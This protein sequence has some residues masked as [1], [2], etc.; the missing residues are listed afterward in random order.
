MGVAFA[1]GTRGGRRVVAL[2]VGAS[3]AADVLW[4]TLTFAGIEGGRSLGSQVFHAPHLPW[5]HSWLSTG[6]L[7]LAFAGL[8]LAFTDRRVALAAAVAVVVHL[9]AGDVPFG[10]GFPATPWSE[11]IA[12]P[13]LYGAWPIAFAIEMACIVASSAIAAPVLGRRRATILGGVLLALHALAWAP[14]FTGE[15]AVDL[16]AHPERI[17]VYLAMLLVAWV[18][19][20]VTTPR[21]HA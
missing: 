20:V 11:P 17:V 10:E 3:V 13:H 9:L 7:A 15:P 18:A 8:G 6:A 2:L 4:C 14:S 16:A 1:R 12:G 21:A 5:S 19:C